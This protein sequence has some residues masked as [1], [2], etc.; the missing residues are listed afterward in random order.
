MQSFLE[1]VSTLLLCQGPQGEQGII[2]PIG[3]TGEKVT[4][5]KTNNVE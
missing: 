3:I 2:G 4:Y 1:N 5:F